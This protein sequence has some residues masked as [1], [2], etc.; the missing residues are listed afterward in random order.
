MDEPS[1]YVQRLEEQLRVLQREKVEYDRE[2]E[3]KEEEILR[4]R[5]DN[6]RLRA[7]LEKQVNESG[8]TDVQAL[9]QVYKSQVE[10]SMLKV[11]SLQNH[12]RS[13]NSECSALDSENVTLAGL[14]SKKSHASPGQRSLVASIPPTKDMER[15]WVFGL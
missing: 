1:L 12:I 3:I 2:S 8:D 4:L 7:A 6:F 15:H 14:L 5:A 11:E 13:L 9:L 10:T